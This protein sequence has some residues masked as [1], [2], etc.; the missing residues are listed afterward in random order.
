MSNT[1]G[2]VSLKYHACI[3][4]YRFIQIKWYSSAAGVSKV[5]V[6]A[7]W[8]LIYSTSTLFYAYF[9]PLATWLTL[10][11]W[12]L[13]GISGGPNDKLLCAPCFLAV[14]AYVEPS[15]THY[16]IWMVALICHYIT[17][18]TVDAYLSYTGRLR[19]RSQCGP[20]GLLMVQHKCL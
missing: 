9:R 15:Q 11:I 5:E 6:G 10:N 19:G 2:L 3:E 17:K 12:Q 16:I 7:N 8:L 14:S 13:K 18:R 4:Y 1:N 20:M